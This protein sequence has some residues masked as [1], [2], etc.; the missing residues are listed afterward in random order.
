VS[1]LLGRFLRR[2]RQAGAVVVVDPRAE[3]EWH[4]ILAE[5]ERRREQAELD[6]LLRALERV[7]RRW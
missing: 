2:W 1:G 3:R 7:S 6:E 5:R 4:R